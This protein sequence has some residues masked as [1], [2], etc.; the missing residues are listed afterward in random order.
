LTHLTLL[1]EGAGRGF[2][3]HLIFRNSLLLFII[4]SQL[5]RE[6]R[7]KYTKAKS[8]NFSHKQITNKIMSTINV[9]ENRPC[10]HIVWS[11]PASE[12]TAMDAFWKEHEEWMR[13]KHQMGPG[14]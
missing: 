7:L 3:V 9:L 1:K 4:T 8:R 13:T 6:V 11:V 12:E 14:N 2:Q 5:L 10:I